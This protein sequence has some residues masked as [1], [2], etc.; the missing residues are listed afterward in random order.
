MLPLES[1]ER[2]FP[3]GGMN[4]NIGHRVEPDPQ[5]VVQRLKWQE[6]LTQQEA[7][8]DVL[9]AVFHLAFS[10]GPVRSAG[11][12]LKPV[13]AGKVQEPRVKVK[14]VGSGIAVEHDLLHVVV[15][16]RPGEAAKVVEG[17]DMAAEQGD[18]VHALGKLGIEAAR[19]AHQHGE[20]VAVACLAESIEAP[21]MAPVNL[22]LLTGHGLESKRG[23]A[24]LFRPQR[25]TA[26]TQDRDAA[27]VALCLQF[28]QQLHGIG[29]AI[30]QAHP[31]VV[32]KCVELGTA[33]SRTECRCPLGGQGSAHGLAVDTKFPGNRTL[34][35]AFAVQG[36]DLQPTVGLNHADLL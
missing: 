7:T 2:H 9:D 34:G 23:L 27:G 32:S 4:P 22:G 33:G 30:G 17:M 1:F 25:R 13:A 18:K 15:E 11:S 5:A 12:G 28:T 8:A 14:L 21:G 26:V 10:L 29:H 6:R 35:A 36:F 31:D 24:L 19:E 20:A 16:Y 3:G